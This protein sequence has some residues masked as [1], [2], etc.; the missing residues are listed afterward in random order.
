MALTPM[1]QQY[2]KLKA[3]YQDCIIFFRLGDFY[4]MFFEDAEIASKELELVLTGRDCGLEE[5]APMCG[6]PYHASKNYIGRLVEKGYKVAICEQLEDPALAKGIVKRDVI[7]IITPGT[8]NDETFLN[9]GRNNYL[10][11]ILKSP[12]KHPELSLAIADITTGEFYTTTFPFDPEILRG[13]IA[14]HSPSEFLVFADDE[15]KDLLSAESS[16]L[17]TE[18]GQYLSPDEEILLNHHFTAITGEIQYNGKKAVKGLLNYLGS[19]QK[20]ALTNLSHLQAYRVADTMALDVNT[21]RNLELTE[22]IVDKGKKGSLIWILDQTMTA[23]GARNIRRWVE[24]PLINQKDIVKRLE[25]VDVLTKHV[26]LME[27]LRLHLKTIYD[28]E[29]IC[30]K[31][32]QKTINARE[33]VALK[34]SLLKIPPVKTL[35]A[36]VNFGELGKIGERLDTLGDIAGL[37]EGAIIDSPS[38]TLKDGDLIKPGFNREIDELRDIKANGKQW[39][40]RL[41]AE[42]REFTGIG[43]LKV[44]YNKVFGYYIEITKSNY[45]KIPEGRYVRKQTLSNAERYI[46]S[47]LKEMEDKILGAEDKLNAL[48]YQLFLNIRDEVELQTDRLKETAAHIADLD[49]YQGFAKLALDRN[50]VRPGFNGDGVIKIEDGR[51]PVVEAM[52]PRGEFIS[53]D[54]LLDFK[55]NNFLIITGPNMA[56]KSTYMRQVALIVLMAQI[57]SFVPA[58]SA[59]ISITDRIFT[60]IGASDDLSGGKST[61]MVEMS[62]VSNILKNATKDSLILLD[63]VGRGTSTYDGLSIAWAVTEYLMEPEGIKART[64]FATHYHELIELEAKIPGIRNYSV[65]VKEYG[66]TIIFLRKIIEGGA[67]ESYGVEVARLAGLPDEVIQRSREIL[68]G[69]EENGSRKKIKDKAQTVYQLNFMDFEPPAVSKAEAEVLDKLRNLD[70]NQLSPLEALNLLNE[71]RSSLRKGE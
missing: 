21:R 6:I 10:M 49:C 52:I 4:E 48:E 31:V 69:L 40:A 27:D 23:M 38:L 65:A 57:G 11:A 29:R 66:N 30:G 51:H 36:G 42:E 53:N 1:M 55:R 25:A 47:E 59:N 16:R 26:N 58:K 62:E 32:S 18:G 33:L 70:I 5:R 54:T 15:V 71:V 43:S 63:E 61:F 7:R 19:T 3:E 64:L 41:E 14:K 20:M 12:D 44:G 67:D 56:G 50:Y 2:F 60:R 37:I 35:L 34:N 13:E 8:L 17:I 24:K 28:I 39:I 22:N 45:G 68:K 9:E 46:T